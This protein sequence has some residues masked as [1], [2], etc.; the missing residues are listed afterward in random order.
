MEYLTVW[1]MYKARSILR[2]T[3]ASILQTALKVGYDSES[4]F[5]RVFKR[6]TGMT[7]GEFRR[8]RIQPPHGAPDAVD[9]F[10]SNP[11]RGLGRAA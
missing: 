4:A 1:R 3:S 9:P 2:G 11:L 8:S 7:P 6:E 10:D 5:N